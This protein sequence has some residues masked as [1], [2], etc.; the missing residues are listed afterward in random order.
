MGDQGSDAGYQRYQSRFIRSSR[1]VGC[2][3]VNLTVLLQAQYFFINAITLL[4]WKQQAI[5]KSAN[6]RVAR[7]RASASAK[8]LM[9]FALPGRNSPARPASLR[10]DQRPTDDTDDTAKHRKS[11]STDSDP[12]AERAAHDFDSSFPAANTSKTR[13]EPLL[14]TTNRTDGCRKEACPDRQEA[15]CAV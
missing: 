6:P 14:L 13:P 2:C 9:K 12:R 4:C 5:S 7:A 10:I 1:R 8:H 11:T 15:H 3:F